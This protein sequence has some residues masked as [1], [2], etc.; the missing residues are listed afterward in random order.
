MT[1]HLR[2]WFVIASLAILFS[3]AFMP[4]MAR[5]VTIGGSGANADCKPGLDYT[6][7]CG[8][9]C[10]KG[11]PPGGLNCPCKDTTNGFTSGYICVG[12]LL[13]KG[14]GTSGKDG[15]GLDQV[16][17]LL[18]G[19]MDKLMQAAKG[20]GGS[21]SGSTPTTPTT[22]CTS[23]TQVSQPTTNPCET[24]VPSVSGYLDS[25]GSGTGT[26]STNTNNISDLLNNLG[27]TNTETD[28]NT[29]T[30][31]NTNVSDALNQVTATVNNQQNTN[32][33]TTVLKAT[34]TVSTSTASQPF[35]LIPGIRGDIT[36]LNNGA[37]FVAGTRNEANNTEVAGFYGAEAT[38]GQQ[39]KGI[40]ANLCQTRPWSGNF[41]SN[42][43]SPTF[44]DSLCAWRGY[45]V[46]T[47]EVVTPQVSVTQTQQAP[48]SKPAT[49]ATTT[50][51]TTTVS[52]VP[53]KVDIWAVPATVPLG[54]RTSI[55]WNTQGVTSCTVSSPDGSFLQNALS[56]GASTVPLT[57][58]TTFTISCLDGN[59][60]P[61]TD[62]VTVTL[63]I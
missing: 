18:G 56:G 41:L 14:T 16:Q 48:V 59:S 31:A 44:F 1:M 4:V 34:T 23:Y 15:F 35:N 28:T 61:V 2:G 30:N 8:Q 26:G 63:S 12:P 9:I 51:A 53:S 7:P 3:V 42:I 45:Q 40:V 6:C 10:K 54:S 29:N 49:T 62:Y 20:G 33:G 25:L 32:T 11:G 13:C 17:K 55:F 47:P 60:K 43:I 5:A 36:V 46:G 58:A 57:G 52:T 24:Y 37:T 27:N 38:L 39:P 50:K 22:A 19:L 21:G